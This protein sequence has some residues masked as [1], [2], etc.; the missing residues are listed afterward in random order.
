[1]N[2]VRSL[3]LSSIF[4]LM[5]GCISKPLEVVEVHAPLLM[6]AQ[7]SDGEVT[8]EWASE[9]DYVYTIYYQNTA[10][11]DWRVLRA[12]NRVP[13]TGQTLT[14]QDRVNPN[15]PLRRYRVLPEKK[16]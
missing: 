2:V 3:L 13:G 15:Q 14:I 10:G 12:A 9:Q 4:I 6:I 7:N 11:G 1:M 16:D 5:A 8:I